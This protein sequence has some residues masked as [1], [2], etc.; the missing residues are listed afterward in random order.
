MV[1]T[2][3]AIFVVAA[4]LLTAPASLIG[5][6]RALK[7]DRVSVAALLDPSSA[8]YGRRLIVFGYYRDQGSDTAHHFG[9]LCVDRESMERGYHPNCVLVEAPKGLSRMS[10]WVDGRYVQVVGTASSEN[11]LSAFPGRLVDVTRIERYETR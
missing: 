11:I 8:L 3:P 4:V 1:R 10:R 7:G 6:T 9:R 2:V 5:Q